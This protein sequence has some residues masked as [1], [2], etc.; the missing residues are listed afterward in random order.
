MDPRFNFTMSRVQ[1]KKLIRYLREVKDHTLR[2]NPCCQHIWTQQMHKM[3]KQVVFIQSDQ[4]KQ[5]TFH[6]VCERRQHTIDTASATAVSTSGRNEWT[7]SFCSVNANSIIMRQLSGPR[8]FSKSRKP[9]PLKHV[10]KALYNF[11]SCKVM[12]KT[13]NCNSHSWLKTRCTAKTLL[14]FFQAAI[15][16][17]VHGYVCLLTFLAV[18]GLLVGWA[19]L[20]L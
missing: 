15:Y 18:E 4:Q 10:T 19:Q 16:R 9:A 8:F 3:H 12:H 17:M 1:N 5:D 2:L 13:G 7:S 20:A 6:N 11:N 14:C